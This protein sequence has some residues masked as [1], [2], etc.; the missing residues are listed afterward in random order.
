MAISYDDF[1]MIVLYLLLLIASSALILGIHPP[2]PTN[3]AFKSVKPAEELESENSQEELAFKG[4]CMEC[5]EPIDW[6]IPQETYENG[7][8]HLC[9]GCEVLRDEQLDKAV[10]ETVEET[11]YDSSVYSKSSKEDRSSSE[12]SSAMFLDK[13]NDYYTKFQN[14]KI[15]I[16]LNAEC[17]STDDMK[18]TNQS[19]ETAE[20]IPKTLVDF[21]KD[22]SI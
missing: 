3:S 20:M 8:I 4:H 15:K 14:S 18:E 6:D 5:D 1:T 9:C 21:I 13:L 11:L 12:D 10:Q 7:E 16:R 22:C 17:T 19:T 2:Q